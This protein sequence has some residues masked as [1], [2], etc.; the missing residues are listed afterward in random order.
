MA[1][2]GLRVAKVTRKRNQDYFAPL[3]CLK[4]ILLHPL[5][6]EVDGR[7]SLQPKTEFWTVL[8]RKS[9]HA[10]TDCLQCF[11]VYPVISSEVAHSAS[12]LDKLC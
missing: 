9:F 3:G 6:F 10:V 7:I 5:V 4:V 1:L 12:D 2:A 11:L 8:M